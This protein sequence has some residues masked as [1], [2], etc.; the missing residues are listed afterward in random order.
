MLQV[1]KDTFKTFIK[2]W[3]ILVLLA[4]PVIAIN[5]LGF[6]STAKSILTSIW[7]LIA[8]LLTYMY[9]LRPKEFHRLKSIKFV[10]KFLFICL[11]LGA[12][13]DL[14]GFV[15]IYLASINRYFAIIFFLFIVF[16][17]IAR[18]NILA[19]MAVME[20]NLSTENFLK[21]TSETYINWMLAVA[22][23]YLPLKVGILSSGEGILSSVFQALETSLHCCFGFA[24]YIRK[25][26]L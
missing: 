13:F 23:I 21:T 10:G 22:I 24:F 4:L 17:L 25:K 8:Q 11:A 5:A 15:T 1:L 3:Q 9:L 19:P 20:E 7:L 18:I 2:N 6:S 12:F 16:Y 26:K 14:F